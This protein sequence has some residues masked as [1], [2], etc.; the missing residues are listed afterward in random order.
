MAKRAL[1]IGV[2]DYEHVNPLSGCLPMVAQIPVMIVLFRVLNGL[3]KH[4]TIQGVRVGTPSYIGH[5]TAL[6][7]ALAKSGGR[8]K[9]F[10]VDFGALPSHAGRGAIV[11][12][13][14]IGLVVVTSFWQMRQMQSRN[15]AA[16][17]MNPQM[18]TIN[19]IMPLFSGFISLNLP[20]GV[21]LYFLISNLFRIT[22]Q[23]LMYRFDPHLRAHMDEV[24][25]VKS[26]GGSTPAPSAPAE[27]RKSLFS[28]LLGGATSETKR[29]G[30]GNST[31]GR[32]NSKPAGEPNRPTSGRV[33][34]PGRPGNAPRK[35]SKRKR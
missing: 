23:S 15:A 3:V 28:G 18:Q 14:L 29:N 30:N 6:Y 20:G 35:R 11:L 16:N 21:T 32:G 25:E 22:Q 24:R 31:N 10:G 13:L 33:T 5:D 1:L 4:K 8:M 7:K 12:Y 34:Q 17:Q 9:S 19:R 2:N 27:P 26:R